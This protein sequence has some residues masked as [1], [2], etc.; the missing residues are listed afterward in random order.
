MSIIV[1]NISISDVVS[2]QII[3]QRVYSWR[4]ASGFSNLGS[5]VQVFHQFAR[6]VDDGGIFALCS[7]ALLLLDDDPVFNLSNKSETMH[8]MTARTDRII[9]SLFFDMDGDLTP[10]IHA[11]NLYFVFLHATMM[12]FESR[13]LAV[14]YDTLAPY[15]QGNDD[16]PSNLF[17]EFTEVMDQLCNM[18]SKEQINADKGAILSAALTQEAIEEKARD[19]VNVLGIM[20]DTL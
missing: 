6:E 16:I 13:Y 14:L 5:L 3:F 12:A 1:K 8:M 9:V 17:D 4:S 18:I 2:G 15:R 7:A 20:M 11:K 10:S 19:Y